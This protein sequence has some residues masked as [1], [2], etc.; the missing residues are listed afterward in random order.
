MGIRLDNVGGF[1]DLKEHIG[2]NIVVVGYGPEDSPVNVAIECWD[3]QCVLV[4]FDEPAPK[5]SLCKWCGAS[6]DPNST[7]GHMCQ[8]MMNQGWA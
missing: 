3:C 6:F 5:K 1:E 4:D 7:H 8:E 2:H